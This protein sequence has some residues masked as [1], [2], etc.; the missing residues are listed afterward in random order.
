MPGHFPQE[1][2]RQEGDG[3]EVGTWETECQWGEVGAV[4]ARSGDPYP[5]Q[6]Q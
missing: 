1:A 5:R 6:R 4:G 3:K 2:H